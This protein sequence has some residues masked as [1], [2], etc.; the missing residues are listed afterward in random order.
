[1]ATWPLVKVCRIRHSWP[2][3]ATGAM[4]VDLPGVRD[5][6]AAWPRATSRRVG[7]AACWYLGGRC[8][9]GGGK[10][11][12]PFH[13][14]SSV[15]STEGGADLAKRLEGRSQPS[16]IAVLATGQPCPTASERFAP[17]RCCAII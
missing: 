5:A 8:V 11:R 10:T 13:N 3:L 9:L 1:M 12:V 15:Q 17:S 2:V 4:L 16:P 7:H 14:H 6:N